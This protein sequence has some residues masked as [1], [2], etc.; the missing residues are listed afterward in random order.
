M[1]SSQ[2]DLAYVYTHTRI[3][4]HTH[5]YYM[6][7]SLSF[8]HTHTRDCYTQEVTFP[9][10]TTVTFA[11]EELETYA[12]DFQWLPGFPELSQ[13]NSQKI[14]YVFL[15]LQPVLVLGRVIRSG[16]CHLQRAAMCN[17]LQKYQPQ[18]PELT[19]HPLLVSKRGSPMYQSHLNV[20]AS[21]DV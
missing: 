6:C 1:K 19:N 8:A 14:W 17:H 18:C 15:T 13:G 2:P 11:Y 16:A 21:I 4:E 12:L 20:M 5:M 10:K 7:I 9:C 3:R